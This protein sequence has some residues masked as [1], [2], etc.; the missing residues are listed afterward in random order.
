MKKN[1]KGISLIVLIITIIVVIILASI[2]LV[3]LSN[4]RPVE[5]ANEA[6][7]K[8]DLSSFKQ[9]L[10]ATHVDNAVD[11][12]SYVKE[13]VNVNLQN[14]KVQGN[15]GMMQKYIPDITRQYSKKLFIKD[16]ELFYTYDEKS[17][18][19]SKQEEKWA[20]EVGV[21]SPYSLV[22]DVNGD[23]KVTDDDKENLQI[24][25]SQYGGGTLEYVKSQT[26][27]SDR[28]LNAMNANQS[29]NEEKSRLNVTDVTAIS[30][31]LAGNV[32]E[33]P[34]TE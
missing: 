18:D 1:K 13:E 33:L 20:R 23:G 11:D 24:I 34:I 3:T 26:G 22:G 25:I 17:G 15:Y 8:S 16:G 6:K 12:P 2:V 4:S 32:D 30:Y 7:F 14:G 10:L 31:F 9:Q 21:G 28:Q 5:K 19:Y 29:N 27:F